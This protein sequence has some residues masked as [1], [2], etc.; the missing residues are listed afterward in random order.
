MSDEYKEGMMR[1]G[2]TKPMI[3]QD[4]KAQRYKRE[5]YKKKN[6]EVQSTTTE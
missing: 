4:A 6:G 1:A 5:A 3:L 2:I